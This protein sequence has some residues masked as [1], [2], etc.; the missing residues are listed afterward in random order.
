[1][2]CFDR[3]Q[4]VHTNSTV[5]ARMSPQWLSELRWLWPNVLWQFACELVSILVPTLCPD[6]SKVSPLWLCLAEG[7][8]ALRCN[9][10]PALLAEWPGSFTCHCSDTGVERVPDRSQHT[11]L[12]LEKKIL[13][14]LLLGFELA[15]IP[16]MSLVLLPTSCSG[17]PV[18]RTSPSKTWM[19]T[20]LF[21]TWQLITLKDLSGDLLI[22][23]L[24]VD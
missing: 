16:N 19:V 2:H 18:L 10:P 6:S 7:V 3:D 24:V 4:L 1:M 11:K 5:Y 20:C 23:C 21:A 12:T 15:T 8:C 13:L 9:L 14:P 22:C 17:C